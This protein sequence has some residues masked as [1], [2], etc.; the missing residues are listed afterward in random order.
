MHLTCT[1]WKIICCP[2][3]YSPHIIVENWD[4][5]IPV[6]MVFYHNGLVSESMSDMQVPHM[7]MY[8]RFTWRKIRIQTR[9]LSTGDT[10]PVFHYSSL[11]DL[12]V[13]V[14]QSEH[15]PNDV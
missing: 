5:H 10:F 6:A 11:R 7:V 14:V 15:G 1:N 12:T 13:V 8:G 4:I 3:R 9:R 2:A